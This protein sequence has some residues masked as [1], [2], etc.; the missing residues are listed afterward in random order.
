MKERRGS[1]VVW[2]KTDAGDVWIVDAKLARG[3]KGFAGK[4]TSL[5]GNK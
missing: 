4:T 5:P 2:G 3:G 1:G